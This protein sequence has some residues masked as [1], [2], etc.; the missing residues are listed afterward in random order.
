MLTHYSSCSGGTGTDST[1]SVI[2]H[3]TSNL[4]FCIW[5]NLQITWCIPV[6]PRRETSMHY[7]SCS[8]WDWCGIHKKRVET[9]YAEHGFLYP[10]GSATYIVHSG[11]SGV[12]NIDAL[13]FMLGWALCGFHKNCAGIRYAKLVFLHPVGCAGHVVHSGASGESNVDALF[14]KLG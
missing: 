14:F 11:V 4:C 7:F 2:G 1:K 5:C 3:V 10:V 12:G 13:F 8:L 9:R 6:H